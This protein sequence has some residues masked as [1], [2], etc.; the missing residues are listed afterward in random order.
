MQAHSKLKKGEKHKQIAQK[1]GIDTANYRF[2][3]FVI[4]PQYF[5]SFLKCLD[6]DEIFPKFFDIELNYQK[7]PYNFDELKKFAI[8]SANIEF[9]NLKES[10]NL[11]KR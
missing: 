5:E 7:T 6:E 2:F 11:V 1:T 8:D 9:R 4:N 3:E 10:F